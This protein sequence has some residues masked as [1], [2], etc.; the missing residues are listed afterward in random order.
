MLEYVESDQHFSLRLRVP[1][2]EIMRHLAV[3]VDV[4]ITESRVA[5]LGPVLYVQ[6]ADLPRVKLEIRGE[7]CAG[8]V[9][10]LLEPQIDSGWY[11]PVQHVGL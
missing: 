7:A 5:H 6:V 2:T 1:K 11:A 8:G 4:G 9:G 10:I 3:R